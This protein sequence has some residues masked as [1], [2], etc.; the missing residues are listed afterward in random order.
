[1]MTTQLLGFIAASL[2][3]LSFIPQVLQIVKT[4]DTKSISLRMYCMFVVGIALWLWYGIELQEWPIIISNFVTF[5]LSSII[6][7]YKIREVKGTKK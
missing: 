7:G 2:T 4:K 3:T 5:V 6:L 1:M